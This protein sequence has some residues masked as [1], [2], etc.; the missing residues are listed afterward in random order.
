LWLIV[1]LIVLAGIVMGLFLVY[2]GSGTPSYH[3]TWG[4]IFLAAGFFILV[5]IE[6][7]LA[8]RSPS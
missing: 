8:V 2:Y 5:A 6:V 3:L 7:Y 4:Y 1:E